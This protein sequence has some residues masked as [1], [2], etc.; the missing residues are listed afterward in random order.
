MP[1][2]FFAS[3]AV[4]RSPDPWPTLNCTLPRV[5]D[6][7]RAAIRSKVVFPAPFTPNKATNSP[8]RI[9]SE[10]PRRATNDP[11]RFST[12]S[13][14]R[15]KGETRGRGV[16]GVPRKAFR[17]ASQQIAQNFFHLPPLA[18]VIV[19]GDGPALAAQLQ[20]EEAVF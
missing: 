11:K 2:S 3:T 1:I 8:E 18:L 6:A 17:V 20:T 13:K 16:T 12:P 14:E 5:G 10:M 19:Q 9:W 7:S 4:E 15:I